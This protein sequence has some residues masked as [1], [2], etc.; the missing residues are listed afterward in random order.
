MCRYL[1][2]LVLL[3]FVSC[4]PKNK[5]YIIKQWHLSPNESTTDIL[6]SKSL[7][8]FDNQID[9]YNKSIKLIKKNSKTIIAEGCEGEIDHE[10]KLKF[11]GWGMSDLIERKDLSDFDDILAP[12]PMK[13]KA[14]FGKKLRVVCGDNDELIKKNNLAFS[15]TKAYSG[16]FQRL[17]FYQNNDLKA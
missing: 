12:V 1:V 2:L 10:F 5:V 15:D 16:F 6:K 13:L 14:K 8:Q 9:I 17:F 4:S 3:I 7:P 11:N